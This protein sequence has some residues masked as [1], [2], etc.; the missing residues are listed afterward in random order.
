MI[1]SFQFPFSGAE[2]EFSDTKAWARCGEV[3]SGNWKLVVRHKGTHLGSPRFMDGITT[4]LPFAVYVFN[5]GI[6]G[7]FTKKEL[8]CAGHFFGWNYY[9]RGDSKFRLCS[10][11]EKFHPVA[12][13]QPELNCI[14]MHIGLQLFAYFG[15]AIFFILFII[16]TTFPVIKLLNLSLIE[17]C[18]IEW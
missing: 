13:I 17:G 5:L 3:H 12:I 4:L 1:M 8:F 9:S 14:R 6:F 10:F 2:D 15:G 11:L 18:A 7:T 16:I